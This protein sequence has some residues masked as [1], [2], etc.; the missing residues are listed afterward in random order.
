MELHRKI[1]PGISFSD[2]SFRVEDAGRYE[3][4]IFLNDSQFLFSVTD[5]DAKEVRHVQSFNFFQVNNQ[6]EFTDSVKLILDSEDL[7]YQPFAKSRVAFYHE[8]S[9][10]VPAEL[11][12]VAKAPAY[13]ALNL[14]ES[15][16]TVTAY[17]MLTEPHVAVV[18]ALPAGVKNLLEQK[19]KNIE[20]LHASTPLLR[21]LL[22]RSAQIAEPALFVYV[23]P[24]VLL[25]LH[26][27][28]GK[29]VFFNAFSYTTPEDFVY[30]I[31]YVCQH[32]HL[33]PE[34]VQLH[35]LGEIV[36][37]S[38]LYEFTYKY[39]RHIHFGKRPDGVKIHDGFNMPEHFYYNLF[40]IGL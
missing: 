13:A 6:R 8:H 24:R 9:T 11:F 4:N 14:E 3:L 18:Y 27:K 31:L 26:A 7:F 25:V 12:D 37:D 29:P 39:V 15:D 22:N 38:V 28:K 23:Q 17:D 21:Q 10:L 34:S 36:K 40:C 32:L 19:F 1:Y 2:P 20:S 33:D 30:Y 35:L 16:D 5:P